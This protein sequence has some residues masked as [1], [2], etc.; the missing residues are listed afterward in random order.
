MNP[1]SKD[2]ITAEVDLQNIGE[3][4]MSSIGTPLPPIFYV[5]IGAGPAAVINHSTLVH[6]EFGKDRL[7]HSP[8]G[9][10]PILHIGFSNP[11]GRYMQH[12]M[13]QLPY[14]LSLPGFKGANQVKATDRTVDGGLDSRIFAKGIDDQFTYLRTRETERWRND[15]TADLVRLQWPWRQAWVAMVQ[16]RAKEPY[17]GRLADEL[18][19]EAVQKQID[20]MATMDYPLF[21]NS[22]L[23]PFRVLVVQKFDS[24]W[25][26]EWIYAQF[27][28]FCTGTGRPRVNITPEK[29]DEHKKALT[30]PWLDPAN[31]IAELGNRR[32]LSGMDAI[33]DDAHW[34]ENERI[35]VPKG[36]GI[37]LNAAEKAVHNKCQ[38][39]WFDDKPLTGTFAN[40]RNYTF[41][42]HW[43]EDRARGVGENEPGHPALTDA[44]LTPTYEKGRLGK[45]AEVESV[46]LVLGGAKVE[47]TLKAKG[48]GEIRASSRQSAG[49]TDGCW[50]AT[51][52]LGNPPSKNYDRIAIAQGLEARG[53]G[54]AM[55]VAGQLGITVEIRDANDGR[56]LALGNAN[57]SIRLLGAAAQVYPGFALIEYRPEDDL[58]SPM[59]RMWGY[60]ATLPVS[61]VPDGFI[62]SGINIAY[63]NKFFTDTLRN[64]NLN[65]LLGEEIEDI[66]YKTG[67]TDSRELADFIVADRSGSNGYADAADLIDKL[68]R[69]AERSA[70]DAAGMGQE[71]FVKERV[72]PVKKQIIGEKAAALKRIADAKAAVKDDDF[73][74]TTLREQYDVQRDNTT[75]EYDEKMKDRIELA[76]TQARI[77]FMDLAPKAKR[78][79]ELV[80]KH[81]AALEK[82]F[83][84]AYDPVGD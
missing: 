68:V 9:K 34:A 52:N 2:V 63:A 13:G 17:K 69:N 67:M 10:L 50:E 23:A 5:I 6:S 16:T 56:M 54:Q 83:Q 60:R 49:L 84:Y 11:W 80:E 22:K 38:L 48:V 74:A 73:F 47:V 66:L 46:K 31:W 53:V 59:A 33:C 21:L 71:R 44:D 58:S 3:T 42:K 7:A 29:T 8:A 36:G 57:Q 35:C 14:L 27:V 1:A 30:P 19:G 25:K 18:G 20:A 26:A 51:G 64:P 55:W 4:G 40:P 43:S 75:K 72:D 15:D 76:A 81:K 62:L 37:A 28:D 70:Q 41:L 79:A 61:T 65:T 82:A 39:D 12:G 32:V 24:E 45:N 78:I 77:E